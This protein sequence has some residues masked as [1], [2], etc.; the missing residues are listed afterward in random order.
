MWCQRCQQDVPAVAMIGDAKVV[1]CARCGNPVPRKGDAEKP[2]AV[3][4]ALR[5]NSPPSEPAD[6]MQSN[7]IEPRRL[8][9]SRLDDDLW[10]AQRLARRAQRQ[11]SSP[12]AAAMHDALDCTPLPSAKSKRRRRRSGHRQCGSLL[13]WSIAG[14]GLSG[15]VCGCALAAWSLL[16]ERPELWNI[17]LPVALVSQVVLAVGLMLQFDASKSS[18]SREDDSEEDDSSVTH[19]HVHAGGMQPQGVSVHYGSA[20]QAQQPAPINTRQIQ[21]EIE[22][23]LRRRAA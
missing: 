15:L 9:E 22:A 19:L 13:G 5:D 18:S 12:A 23:A 10:E 1:C 21:G 14:L 20:L 4:D 7:V 6:D 17:G 2:A 11:C 3:E 16:G 8:D